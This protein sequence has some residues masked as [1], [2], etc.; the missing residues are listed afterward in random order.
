MNSTKLIPSINSS[1]LWNNTNFQCQASP[2]VK[3]SSLLAV[4]TATS[5][6]SASR[7]GNLNENTTNC[8]IRQQPLSEE[9]SNKWQTLYFM[10]TFCFFSAF[11][12]GPDGVFIRTSSE[13][14]VKQH[15]QAK[16]DRNYSISRKK[17]DDANI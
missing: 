5:M 17:L 2:I 10:Q 9:H 13:V 8:C 6:S 16:V 12:S 7:L 11:V 15:S 4:C 1:F 14:R 3:Y